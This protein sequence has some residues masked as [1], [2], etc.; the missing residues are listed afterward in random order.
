MMPM[1]VLA[2]S[3]ETAYDMSCKEKYSVYGKSPYLCYDIPAG[4]R[5]EQFK[6]ILQNFTPITMIYKE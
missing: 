6:L 1:N 2:D 4:E 5:T 3:S